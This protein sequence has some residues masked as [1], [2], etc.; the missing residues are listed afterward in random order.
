[1]SVKE[2]H[3]TMDRKYG[4]F[5]NNG[6]KYVITTPDIPRN[7]YNYLWNDRYITF[8]SQTGAG[9]GFLQDNMGKR[10][11]LVKERGFYILEDFY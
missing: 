9:E 7:W 3:F 4:Y 6:K 5:S 11:P 2:S 1:M 10:I 8:T